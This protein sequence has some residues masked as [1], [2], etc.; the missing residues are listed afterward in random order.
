MAVGGVADGGAL[1]RA[2]TAAHH[3]IT[4]HR[5]RFAGVT[6]SEPPVQMEAQEEEKDLWLYR[7]TTRQ[8]A[9]SAPSS[10]S[11]RQMSS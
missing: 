2:E 8:G 1:R 10:F 4:P 7:S 9:P 5:A 6:V 11:G 3:W